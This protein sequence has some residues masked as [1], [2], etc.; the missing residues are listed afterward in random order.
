M[1]MTRQHFEAIA[2]ALKGSKPIDEDGHDVANDHYEQGRMDQWR[3]DVR[4][5]AGI[6]RASNPRFD[7]RFYAACDYETTEA[8]TEAK[9][10]GS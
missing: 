1:T 9:G 6:L 7:A 4:A 3:T 8:E 5:I 2:L 10:S